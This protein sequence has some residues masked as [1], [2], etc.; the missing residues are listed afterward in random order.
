MV[1]S[2]HNLPE[3][4][5][6]TSETFGRW[7][8]GRRPRKRQRTAALQDASVWAKLLEC[9][10]PLCTL[11]A[12]F[13]LRSVCGGAEKSSVRS[14]MCWRSVG[15]K[16]RCVEGQGPVHAA[17]TE[18]GRASCVA[19]TINMA[20]L[21]E[22]SQSPPKIRVRRRVLWRF[23][24]EWGALT[25]NLTRPDSRAKPFSPVS[26]LTI[27]IVQGIGADEFAFG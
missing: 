7:Q 21:P 5:I 4:G 3:G 2:R 19:V 16:R 8:Q 6:K 1:L 25:D 18:L 17:P 22:L 10:S 14:A 11:H 23:R 20:L 13:T 15:Q 27:E 24:T 12:S 9:A 26:F